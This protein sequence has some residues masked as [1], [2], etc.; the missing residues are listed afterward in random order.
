M[1]CRF[2]LE[3]DDAPMISPCRCIGSVKY[4]HSACLH[5]WI[6]EG[7]QI[8]EE[9]LNCTICKY[10]LFDL[11]PIPKRDN[12][13][14]ASLYNAPS[15]AVV[16]HYL[17]LVTGIHSTKPAFYHFKNSQLLIYFIYT[18]LF[19]K[20]MRTRH[21]RLYMDITIE[22]HLLSYWILQ[23]YFIH[24]F[25]SEE[26]VVMAIASNM[27]IVIQWNMHVQTLQS[28]NEYLLKN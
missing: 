14:Y 20:Y 10:P 5:R 23:I 17:F 27:C 22:K 24:S 18:L 2:C 11:E 25:L 21:P 8:I 28:I 13:V 7:D 6:R 4:I 12:V 15:V 19:A 3:A 1:Q 26:N 16:F 9:R